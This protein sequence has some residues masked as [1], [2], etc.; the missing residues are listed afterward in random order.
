M[1]AREGVMKSPVLGEDLQ[2]LYPISMEG[3]SDTATFDNALELLT[4]AGYPLACS[5]NDD[6][7][8]SLGTAH[9]DGRASPRVLRI[10]RIDD[11]AVDGPA[12]MVFTDGARSAPRSTVTVCVRPVSS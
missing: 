2:K 5:S 11:G 4:M 1:R 10:P 8:G 12:A 7:P 6:D 3:Q 9:A